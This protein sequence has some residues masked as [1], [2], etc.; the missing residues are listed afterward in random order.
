MIST[1][2]KKIN[3][4]I[5]TAV[6]SIATV[7]LM[8][9]TAQAAGTYEVYTYGSGDFI[10]QVLI[11]IALMFSG[12]FIQALIKIVLIIGLLTAILHPVTEWMQRG[13]PRPMVGGNALIIVFRQALLAV[14]AVYI[15]ILPKASIAIIDRLDPAQSQVVAEIP[16][17][18]A[19]IAHGTSLIGDTIGHKMEQ[20]FSL[21]DS[22][23]FSNGGIALGIKYV[24]S[25]FDVRPPSSASGPQGAMIT[26][27]LN[28]YFNDCVFPVF[29]TLDGVGGPRTTALANLANSTDLL[30]TLRM[31]P[32]YADPNIIIPAPTADGSSSCA[33]AITH[34][35]TAWSMVQYD[36][37][38]ETETRV[39]QNT[40]LDPNI[41]GGGTM[42]TA[43]LQYYF[44]NS[45]VDAYTMLQSIAIG[46]LM[47]DAVRKYNAVHGNT[48]DLSASLATSSTVSGWQTTARLFNA[49]VH[50][51]R[52]LFE[53]LIYGLAVFLPIAVAA[54]GL[55]PIGTY[56]KIALWLQLW[57][58]FY[59]L[60]NLFAEMEMLRSMNALC[61]QTLLNSPSVLMWQQVGEKAQLSLGYVGSLAFT[62]PMFAWGLLKGGEYAMSSAV[63]SMVSG[64]GLPAAGASI[65]GQVGGMGNVSLGQRS[66]DNTSLRSST[67]LSS[68]TAFDVNQGFITGNR[69]AANIT[70]KSIQGLNS[71]STAAGL[72]T[73]GGNVAGQ[74]GLSNVFASATV[75]GKQTIGRAAGVKAASEGAGV[76]ISQGEQLTTHLDRSTAIS[77][78]KGVGDLDTAGSWNARQ[79]IASTLANGVL[80]QDQHTRNA[81]FDK[82]RAAGM[83]E[84]S[85]KSIQSN[86]AGTGSWEKKTENAFKTIG[87][88]TNRQQ[89][90]GVNG[91]KNLAHATGL[92][93]QGVLNAGESD[94][95]LATAKGSQHIAATGAGAVLTDTKRGRSDTTLNTSLNKSG[96]NIE[97]SNVAGQDALRGDTNAF[98]KNLGINVAM[99]SD[100]SQLQAVNKA[101]AADVG[102]YMEDKHIGA[103]QGQGSATF[104]GGLSTPMGGILHAGATISER[105]ST[106]ATDQT[107]RNEVYSSI[108]KKSEE[109]KNDKTITASEKTELYVAH[110]QG[111]VKEVDRVAD[112]NLLT[113]QGRNVVSGATM[114]KVEK[115]GGD[116]VR[117]FKGYTG[118]N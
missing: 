31:E 21:P 6:A 41:I 57:I 59:V 74:G 50:T 71:Q 72:V 113:R 47:R 86:V 91:T 77:T 13:E 39:S 5:A 24:N 82:L 53:G 35:A 89:F 79:N 103:T 18:Q 73:T 96:H 100:A 49:I 78:A 118:A 92:S 56:I 68:R 54:A 25:I 98:K 34:I 22:M 75:G 80:S 45:T 55:G 90:A 20:A 43:T 17:V 32:L 83:T 23:K 38:K 3:K 66:I 27:S 15:L 104:M 116:I 111:L 14:V 108:M 95:T 42:T 28:R 65:G 99:W 69:D 94:R 88:F 85:I 109:L 63:G 44:P 40:T 48:T 60:M 36:W 12:N 70:G 81:T 114:E 30:T 67:S 117:G 4:G 101:V 16:L 107:S 110:I 64:G 1:A 112:S 29:G 2:N 93:M 105:T 51:M 11:G 26:E 97:V 87:E 33:L 102:Q 58:P 46:N 7:L 19:V 84:G 8:G 10:A 52:N 9:A 61:Q 62:I 76:T 37:L 115:V 106:T